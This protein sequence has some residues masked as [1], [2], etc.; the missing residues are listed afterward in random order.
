LKKKLLFAFPFV[1]GAFL[2]AAF[3]ARP[4]ARPWADEAMG[5]DAG[6]NCTVI[7][8]GRDASTDGSTMTTHTCDC[9]FC[10]WTF[11]AVPA[12]DHK[13]GETR[14]IY[15][16]DQY[17]TWPPAQGLKWDLI[18]NDFTGLEI[19][20]VPHTYGYIHGMFG[21]LNDQQLAIGESSIGCR[22]KMENPTPAAKFDLTMLTLMA[23]ER[24]RMAR[25][26]IA[27]M[28]SLAES[29]GYGY[30]DRGEMLA[31]ADP[32]EVWVFEIM[33]VGPLWTP[34]SGKPG[35]V[36]C[37]E[38]VPDD[39]VSVCP[40]ESRIGEIDLKNTKD[41]MAS[42]NVIS[43]GVENGFYDPKSGQPFNWKKAYDPV[44]GS[45]ATSGRRTR[46]WRFF[47]LVAPSRNL[48]PDLPNMDYPFSVKPD[49]KIA[50]E[51][52]MTMTRDRCQG[53]EFDPVKGI[54]GGPFL[55]PNVYR[56]TRTIGTN[57]AEYTTITQ[58]R[59]WL[60]PAVGGL[61][62]VAFGA[63]DT[64]C[65]MPLYAG[66]S[67]VPPSFRLGDHF[68]LNRDSA[69][70]AFDYVDALAQS[71]YMY[72]LEDIKQVRARY[73]QAILAQIPEVDKEAAARFARSPNEGVGYLDGFC[74]A[75]ADKV[76][77]AW[78]DLGDRL[79]VKY[80]HGGVYNTDKRTR[81]NGQPEISDTWRKAVKMVD[82]WVEP[83]NK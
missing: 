46:I 81:D 56:E 9:G 32:K 10:D 27:F 65:Y 44:D 53:T 30:F 11:R 57:R 67:D 73:E 6:D 35:A 55:N 22:K 66:I 12:A 76:V 2:L 68:E 7:M 15:H 74:W 47:N 62:W 17:K 37:A 24:C 71:L 42:P 18:K 58:S 80:D 23:M 60:P 29:Y 54:R 31:V 43:F 39:E 13:P 28:G 49:K 3:I 20:E 25:Q 8:V 41:F 69:R 5:S 70:W 45:A 51:D 52:V 79:L 26:A 72:A 78:W 61:V 40:N 34:K 33:P 59:A 63:Q 48:A 50:V 38:R 77:K 64:S 82:T 4:S 14:R 83:A 1:G 16:I 75:N 36:W 21:Y 19:P